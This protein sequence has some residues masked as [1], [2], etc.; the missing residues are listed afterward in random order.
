MIPHKTD[1]GRQ[2]LVTRTTGLSVFERRLVI[3][4]DGQRSIVALRALL[5]DEVVTALPRLIEEGFLFTEHQAA[6]VYTS[7]GLNEPMTELWAGRPPHTPTAPANEAAAQEK[8]RA[9]APNSVGPR[10]SLAASK[11]YLIDMLQLLR[12]H[13]GAAMALA[14]HTARAEAD[15]VVAMLT[16]LDQIDQRCGADYA[17]K[18]AR[19]LLQTLPLELLPHFDAWLRRERAHEL[20]TS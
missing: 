4:A 17:L 2:A 19:H 11:Y 18:V 3:M 12:S 20:A 16:S 15:V 9:V 6:P 5:G 7:V 10:R 14:L 8:G 13:E 1:K